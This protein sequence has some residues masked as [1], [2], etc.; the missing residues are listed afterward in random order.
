MKK[1]RLLL[2]PFSLLYGA[3]VY[4]R[5]RLYDIGVLRSERGA[6]PTLVIGNLATGGT[7]KTPHAEY[8]IRELMEMDIRVAILSRGYG[9]K[10]KGF[11][12]ADDKSTAHTIG[13]EPYQIHRKFPQLPLAVCEDRLHGIRE[14]KAATDAQLVLLD[15]A[16]QHRRLKG[17]L[18]ILLTTY[19][20]PFWRDWMLPAGNLRD[21]QRE[22][23]RADIILVT[24]CPQLL[25]QKEMDDCV[26]A[27]SPK[28]NQF[29]FF[30]TLV[31]GDPIQLSGRPTDTSEIKEVIG[32]A[33]IAN[34][35]PFEEHLTK[36][37]TL[38]KFKSFP[39]HYIFSHSDI[40][41]LASE[42]GKFGV[43]E[44]VMVTTE[45]D[46]MRLKVMNGL[47]D[48][49]VFYVPIAVEILGQAGPKLTRLLR[50]RII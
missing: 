31:Y 21:N 33:G 30:S 4:L 37:Y 14:L 39:D 22:K 29:V 10:T 19:E 8:F 16:L 20:Q 3:V 7:G 47:P 24:K 15:D 13:D 11:I 2:Y 38:K 17:D 1:L 35:Q 6:L 44:A 50:E 36:R 43:P 27:I 41:R 46:A 28:A 12:M 23:Q 18:N 9:R 40:E 45:K 34:Y 32:F 26:R 42:C 25:T 48:V 5:N 49:P